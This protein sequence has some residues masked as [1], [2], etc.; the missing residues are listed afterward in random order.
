MQI[1]K[2]IKKNVKSTKSK[3]NWTQSLDAAMALVLFCTISWPWRVIFWHFDYTNFHAKSGVC[4]SKNGWVIALGTKEDTY[5]LLYIIT[6]ALA[7][8]KL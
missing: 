7:V 8:S 4:S 6:R 5:I 3:N 1:C 2:E